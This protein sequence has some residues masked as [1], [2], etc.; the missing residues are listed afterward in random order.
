MH[1][2]EFTR[3]CATDLGLILGGSQAHFVTFKDVQ[4]NPKTFLKVE[5][6]LLPVFGELALPLIQAPRRG[7]PQ[8]P[9]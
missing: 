1:F 9:H 6:Q 7:L 2:K 3:L 8:R 5:P 4:S